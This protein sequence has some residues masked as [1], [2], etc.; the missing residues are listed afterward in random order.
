[1]LRY[2]L[3]TITVGLHQEGGRSVVISIPAGAIIRVQDGLI[4]TTGLIR[5]EWR[6]ES[7]RIFAADLHA[8]GELM[9]VMKAIGSAA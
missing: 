9:R 8:R 2:R 5:V 4:N 3:R 6:M 1:M 7:I